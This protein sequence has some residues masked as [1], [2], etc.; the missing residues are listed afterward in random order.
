MIPDV[1]D[2]LPAPSQMPE[3]VYTLPELRY[4]RHLNAGAA[5]LD[6]NAEGDRAG[7]SRSR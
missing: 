1:A 2:S 5:L 3:R 6:A 4:P 7:R